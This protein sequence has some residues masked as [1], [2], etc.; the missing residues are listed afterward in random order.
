MEESQIALL[1]FLNGMLSEKTNK[2]WFA[3]LTAVIAGWRVVSYWAGLF[4]INNINAHIIGFIAGLALVILFWLVVSRLR[5]SIIASGIKTDLDWFVN[6]HPEVLVGV[7]PGGAILAG[8]A[9]KL[10]NERTKFEPYVIVA[11]REFNATG[12]F[13]E[14]TPIKNFIDSAYVDAIHKGKQIGDNKIH[15]V[16]ICSEVHTGATLKFVVDTVK[17]IRDKNISIKTYAL[18]SAPN[19]DAKV[20]RV[21]IRSSLRGLIPWSDHPQRENHKAGGKSG[22]QNSNT[23][24]RA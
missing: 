17:E 5:L 21:L 8:I 3:W 4:G 19:S 1:N 7:G 15:I 12:Q 9:A 10:L 2:F 22:E 20:D 24:R 14:R 11:N 23:L 16:I 18:I 13:L 6:E